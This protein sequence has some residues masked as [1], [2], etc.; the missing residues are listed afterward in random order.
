MGWRRRKGQVG[1]WN[2]AEVQNGDWAG[3]AIMSWALW[4]RG[5]GASFDPIVC[6]SDSTER[7]PLP[8]R[9]KRRGEE[10]FVAQCRRKEWAACLPTYRP[11]RA[12]KGTGRE[13]TCHVGSAAPN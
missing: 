12:G 5:I 11:L 13:R 4:R 9:M 10:G 8:T 3:V 1:I 7:A 6:K 2:E